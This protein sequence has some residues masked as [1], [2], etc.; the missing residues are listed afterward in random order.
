MK[1]AG[2]ESFEN[3]DIEFFK[4]LIGQRIRLTLRNR[5]YYHGRILLLGGSFM[6]FKDK[7]GNELIINFNNISNIQVVSGD[8]K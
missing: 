5:F 7:F 8:W 4:N 6:K 3:T 2:K 1:Y